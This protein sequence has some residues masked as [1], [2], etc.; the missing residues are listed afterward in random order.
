[1][2][3]IWHNLRQFLREELAP[4]EGRLGMAWRTAAVC[5]LVTMVFM[6]Y[7]IPLAPI[8]CYLVLFVMKPN[9]AESL[10][11]G[12]GIL[13]LVALIMLPLLVLLAVISVDNVIVRMLV[14][15][16]GSFLF[17]YLSVA[18]KVGEVGSIIALV[19]GFIMTLI[20]MA[21]VGELV[22]RAILYAGL[23]AVTPVV[24]M[25]LFLLVLGPSPAQQAQLHLLRRWQRITAVLNGE[26]PVNS[27]LL[28]LREGNAEINKM[29]LFA[30]LFAQVPK[31]R[32]VQLKQL[33]QSSYQLMGALVALPAGTD[34]PTSVRPLW[35]ARSAA[36]V[37]ALK[38]QTLALPSQPTGIDSMPDFLQDIHARLQCLP[39]VPAATVV[40]SPLP[41]TGFL[42]DD[43]ATNR[44]Y[45]EFGLKVT[46]CAVICYLTYT[47]LQWQD[48]HTAMI[49]CYVAALGTV[50]ETVRKLVLRIAGCLVGAVLGIASIWFLM[51][52]M[53]NIGQLM[54]LV[55]A[56]CLAAAWVAQGSPRI[57]YAGLQIGLAFLLSVLQ[58]FG[59]NVS[60]AVALDRIYGILLGNLVM[61]IVFTQ[62]WPVSATSQVLKVLRK[63]VDGFAHLLQKPQAHL[64]LQA[65]LPA[66]IPQLQALRE[67]AALG[68]FESAA[69]HEP[70]SDPAGMVSRIDA[71][72]A[73]YLKTA[74]GELSLDAP[75]VQEQVHALQRKVMTG[76]AA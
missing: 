50:G 7:A 13:V 68:W 73:V 45:A 76:G 9:I 70:V 37:E 67:Q 59:P 46:F 32:L 74:F 72:E 43:V 25:L 36:M 22:T 3:V 34:I 28:N 64:Q 66:L 30:T 23:M 5:A 52:H 12:G 75:N 31:A 69:L 6:V 63:H 24:L 10:M 29:L 26:K 41:A 4:Y 44:S 47:A 21:P 38:R 55:F 11:M 18:S 14:L 1:M 33:T 57:S 61:F 65:A 8:A 49:T 58:G 51:P 71:L 60:I 2:R 56:G 42:N 17:M 27:L 20:G 39:G 16:M 35:G 53:T 62:L 15:A 40:K 54:A 48:I 19:I